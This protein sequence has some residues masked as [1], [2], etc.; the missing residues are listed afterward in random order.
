MLQ[1]FKVVRDQITKVYKAELRRKDQIKSAI[2]AYC[3]FHKV[4]KEK[5]EGYKD[6]YI[7]PHLRGEMRPILSEND[8]D[9]HIDL[10]AHEIDLKIEEFMKSGSG[11]NLVRIEMLTIETYTYRRAVGGSYIPTP[12]KLASK[13]CTINPDNSN[14]IDPV[15]G[16]ASDNCLQGVLACYFAHKNGKRVHLERIF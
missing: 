15:T 4:V 11:W 9:E 1:L 2:V 12:V 8:I 16:K 3:I 6:V 7:Y 5:D 13:K 14:I 10:S